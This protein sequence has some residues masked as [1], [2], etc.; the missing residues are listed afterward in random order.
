[1]FKK[2][3]IKWSNLSITSILQIKGGLSD[4]NIQD[5]IDMSD[6]MIKI[7]KTYNFISMKAFFVFKFILKI[8]EMI[9]KK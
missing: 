9:F 4:G 3:N 1:M 7:L 5:K 6:D 8:K 2:K